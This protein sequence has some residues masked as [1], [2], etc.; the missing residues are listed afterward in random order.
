MT[1]IIT[2]PTGPQIIAAMR[3][4]ALKPVALAAAFDVTVNTIYDWTSGR[5]QCAPYTLHA[6]HALAEK[7]EPLTPDETQKVWKLLGVTRQHAH[8]WKTK[9]NTPLAARYAAAWL[10]RKI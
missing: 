3:N 6:I 5:R 9:N 2:R 10:M 4:Y 7:V 8:S 1:D